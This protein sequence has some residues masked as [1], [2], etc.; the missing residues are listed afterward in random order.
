VQQGQAWRTCCSRPARSSS[1]PWR[2]TSRATGQWS[3]PRCQADTE[4]RAT[5]GLPRG[6]ARSQDLR[7]SEDLWQGAD[8]DAGSEAAGPIYGMDEEE[9]ELWGLTDQSWSEKRES[10]LGSGR[11]TPTGLPGPGVLPS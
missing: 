9:M 5:R 2:S 3:E 1:A 11:G 4:P 6:E 8:A 7:Q 10:I